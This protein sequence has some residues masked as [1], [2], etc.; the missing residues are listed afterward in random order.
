MT[1]PQRP[2][3]FQTSERLSP[4][5][6]FELA[7]VLYLHSILVDLSRILSSDSWQFSVR[8]NDLAP[9]RAI[10]WLAKA[11]SEVVI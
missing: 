6:A 5:A 10:C 1:W 9:A 3:T 8:M 4:R 7:V 2:A 11:F